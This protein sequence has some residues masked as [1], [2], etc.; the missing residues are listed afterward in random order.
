MTLKGLVAFKVG[1]FMVEVAV[2]GDEPLY[3]QPPTNPTVFCR[4]ISQHQCAEDAFFEGQL[5]C[6]NKQNPQSVGGMLISCSWPIFDQKTR[7]NI[8]FIQ[9]KLFILNKPFIPFFVKPRQRI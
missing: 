6:E 3:A 1:V 8:R 2:S 7:K 9:Y 5:T 4:W